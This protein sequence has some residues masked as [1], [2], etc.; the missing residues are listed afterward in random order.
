[1]TSSIPQH[2]ILVQFWSF[3]VAL[4]VVEYKLQ[5]YQY[6]FSL[7]SLQENYTLSFF[8]VR[9]IHVTRMTKDI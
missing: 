3:I 6:L 7:P 2:F 1:M 5:L 4:S 9:L 8:K